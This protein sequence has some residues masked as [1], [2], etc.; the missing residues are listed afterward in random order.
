MD[1]FT[2]Q[3]NILSYAIFGAVI[4]GVLMLG[5]AYFSQKELVAPVLPTRVLVPIRIDFEFLEKL[6][7]KEFSPFERVSAPIEFGRV[8]PFEAPAAEPSREGEQEGEQ[9]GEVE[10]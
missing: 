4:A 8:E 10:Q 2:K 6:T 3:K 7:G 5:F 1:I 9:E